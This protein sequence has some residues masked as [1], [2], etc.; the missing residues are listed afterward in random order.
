M[1]RKTLSTAVAA[2]L[3]TLSTASWGQDIPV[4]VVQQPE[5]EEVYVLGEFI[6]DEKRDTSEISNV[7]DEE[8]LSALGETSVGISLQRVT[9]L[10]LVGGKYV[11]VRGLGERYSSTLLNASRISSPVPFQKTI[12]LDIVPN[13][14]VSSLLV[15]KTYSAQYPGDFSG[16]VVDIRTKST[17]DE[18]FFNFKL[19]TGGNSETTGGDGLTYAGGGADN[20]G[21]D[22]GTRE[23]P[24][25]IVNI[26]SE[27][28]EATDEIQK[29]GLGDSFYN[30]WDVYVKD[31][32]PD[33]SGEFELGK[34]IDFDGDMAL[35]VIGAMKYSN[36]YDNR[37]EEV[38]RY[39]FSGTGDNSGTQTVDY[40]QFTTKQ[41]I[42]F[43]G[44][45]TV[46]FEFDLDNS[47]SLTYVQ[48]R[49]TED[50][51]EQTRGDSSEDDV[52]DGTYVES[53]RL[54]WTENEISSL[55]LSGEHFFN[56]LNEAQL[57]WRLVDG[58]A[59]RD[60]P[61]TRTYTYA[62]NRDG[63]DEIVT[64]NRQAAGDL[65]DVFQAPE[66]SYSYLDDDIQDMGVDFELPTNLGSVDVIFKAGA[67]FYERTRESESRLF[68]FDLSS[69]AP[70][71]I[72]LMTP[73]QLWDTPN[74]AEG[75][76]T[77]RDFSAGAANASGIFPFAESGEEVGSYYAAFDAQV[78]PRVRLQGG[79]RQEEVTLTADAWGGNTEQG[80]TNFVEQDY[81]DT[82][83]S[84]SLTWE[85]LDNMQV[86]LAYSETVNRPSLLEITGTTIRNPEDANLYRGNVFLQPAQLENY[87]FRWEWYFG[88]ADSMS[89][90]AFA[91]DFQNPIEL[92]KVQAQ[93]D[94][95]TWF[96]ADSAELRGIE[97]DISKDLYFG[98]WFGLS[99][100]WDAFTVQANVSWIDS[101][102]TLLGDGETA[103]DVPLTGGRNVAQFNANTRPI[104]GQSDWLGNVML[105]YRDYSGKITA[106]LAYN[107]TGERTVLVGSRNAPDV[108][109][110]GR[111]RLDALFRYGLNAFDQ[112]MQIEFKAGNL[113][114][115]EVEWL[116]GGNLY[117][118]YKPGISYSVGLRATF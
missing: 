9:G 107:Y 29:R 27:E 73:Q 55:Q 30:N 15:Q 96:N 28:F 56:S 92:A 46:G 42:D 34:R 54:Q 93:N 50:E 70:S 57:N 71:Y 72:A 114:D 2:A 24:K 19:G 116:Q 103:V 104:T 18:D 108:I 77:V 37:I 88:D 43:S 40:D 26:S 91:K 1:N 12:P 33:F 36:S 51:L 38:A 69:R 49:Q 47:V 64:P 39:E 75:Y 45:L 94:V 102:V 23:Q 89:L 3:G 118:R 58:R 115:A 63:M 84:L 53:Y 48:L 106:T 105:M 67:G 111:G 87:D 8:D 81:T 80:T 14:I 4:P 41:S 76:L 101:E 32:K 10:S 68:R 44:F 35:G 20:W 86:R 5:I 62:E 82:L 112:E 59:T 65:R 98:E 6:P 90:G 78:H 21:W 110:Q 113:L 31:M 13:Q 52:T 100:A 25:N 97:Y 109:E 95:Y 7:M 17:P 66:R 83:P 99:P 85:F 74:W 16:G 61:D 11:Y 79:V 117:E 60:E 22:D